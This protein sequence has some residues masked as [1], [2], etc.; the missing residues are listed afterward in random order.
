MNAAYNYMN[1]QN[2]ERL[3]KKKS[4]EFNETIYS[5][6]FK[7]GER[8]SRIFIIS[9][10]SGV[11]DIDFMKPPNNYAKYNRSTELR[12]INLKSNNRFRLLATQS[13]GRLAFNKFINQI[14][15]LLKRYPDF[16]QTVI[17]TETD[18]DTQ[19]LNLF[20]LRYLLTSNRRELDLMSYYEYDDLIQIYGT[21]FITDFRLFPKPLN[22]DL[23]QNPLNKGFHCYP[24]VEEIDSEGNKHFDR[25]T[26]RGVY[27]ITSLNKWGLW[28]IDDFIKSDEL[29]ELFSDQYDRA[30]ESDLF[31]AK[32][33]FALRIPDKFTIPLIL[34][35]KG[36][37]F[38][39]KLNSLIKMNREIYKIYLS[40]YRKGKNLRSISISQKI[41][42][43]LIYNETDNG[44]DVLMID[45]SCS[46]VI[47]KD[48]PYKNQTVEPGFEWIKKYRPKRSDSAN[49]AIENKIK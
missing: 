28:D 17:N 6:Y 16:H 48:Y 18:G 3:K 35:E 5:S 20:L 45:N 23:E 46:P 32:I 25:D 12:D 24:N 2:R 41:I 39:D 8:N 30:I 40:A 31:I 34:D 15:N 1:A 19:N 9:G 26:V 22:P 27:E 33:R 11:S 4:R 7:S 14:I 43:D 49:R 42:Y 38:L 29:R 10:H 44:D 36:E 13:L 37:A 47:Q 21:K